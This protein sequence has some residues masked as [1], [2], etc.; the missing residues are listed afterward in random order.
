MADSK[1]AGQRVDS[2]FEK[3]GEFV[4]NTIKRFAAFLFFLFGLGAVFGAFFASNPLVLF[5]PFAIA[6]LAYYSRDFAII[7]LVLFFLAF[8]LIPI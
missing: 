7:I 1:K 5:I 4:T 8:F 2:I 3:F 6:I